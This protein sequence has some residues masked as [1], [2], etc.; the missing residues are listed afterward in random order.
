MFKVSFERK[1]A[2]F[3]HCFFHRAGAE[4]PFDVLCEAVLFGSV[5]PILLRGKYMQQ[6][7]ARN[8]LR[9][10]RNSRPGLS[11]TR[12]SVWY[13]RRIERLDSRYIDRWGSHNQTDL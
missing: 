8:T 5:G 3:L 12:Q 6:A 10:L 4:H 11:R 2:R 9:V 1:V 7:C 13:L